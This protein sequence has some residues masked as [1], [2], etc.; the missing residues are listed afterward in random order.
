LAELK[1]QIAYLVDIVTRG[2]WRVRF[3]G[4]Q[5][6]TALH[7]GLSD[8]RDLERKVCERYVAQVRLDGEAA[9]ATAEAVHWPL[10]LSEREQEA[11]NRTEKPYLG[12][13]GAGIRKIAG[14]HVARVLKKSETWLRKFQD[15]RLLQPVSAKPVKLPPP[16]EADP[17]A[18]FRQ[19][20]PP[21]T[22]SERTTELRRFC[23]AWNRLGRGVQRY[24]EGCGWILS[25]GQQHACSAPCEALVRGHTHRR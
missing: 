5:W 4:T 23:R 13:R 21:S 19:H 24:C 9:L 18:Y 1:F 22:E 14:W 25:Q 11:L 17:I 10:S 8:R 2:L 16:G 6:P 15:G 12:K 20:H 3:D 7:D